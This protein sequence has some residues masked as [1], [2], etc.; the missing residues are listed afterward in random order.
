MTTASKLRLAAHQHHQSDSPSPEEIA[1]IELAIDN[2][3]LSMARAIFQGDESRVENWLNSPHDGLD[4][5]APIYLLD[6]MAGVDRV[7]RILI[8]IVC[9]FSS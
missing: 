6:T 3:I 4:K 7:G 2:K 8:E 5:T 1:S 9:G